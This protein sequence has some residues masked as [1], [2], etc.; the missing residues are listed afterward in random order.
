MTNRAATVVNNGSTVTKAVLHIQAQQPVAEHAAA[1]AVV[2]V[3][4]D[5][6]DTVTF[7]PH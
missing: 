4:A 1:L 5:V 6:V 2:R 7:T 3:A